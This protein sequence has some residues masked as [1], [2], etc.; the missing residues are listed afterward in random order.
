MAAK[1]WEDE[2]G[3]EYIT[4]HFNLQKI[5]KY[6]RTRSQVCGNGTRAVLSHGDQVWEDTRD[7]EG[8]A[9]LPLLRLSNN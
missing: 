2:D 8:E 6:F 1:T 9:K 4:K 3:Q 5:A 7:M